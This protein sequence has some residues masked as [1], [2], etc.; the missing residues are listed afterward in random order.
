MMDALLMSLQYF[1]VYVALI[2]LISVVA[3][4]V[5]ARRGWS[6]T[7]ASLILLLLTCAPAIAFAVGLQAVVFLTGDESA[8]RWLEPMGSFVTAVAVLCAAMA[9]TSFAACLSVYAT[10]CVLTA[11]RICCPRAHA[12]RS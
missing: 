9:V 2:A 8:L 12:I 1:P 5:L 3:G 10:A 6:L 11:I 4:V 7:R